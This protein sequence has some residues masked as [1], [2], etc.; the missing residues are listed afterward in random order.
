MPR[1]KREEPPSFK[2]SHDDAICQAGVVQGTVIKKIRTTGDQLSAASDLAESEPLKVDVIDDTFQGTFV[3]QN[4]DIRGDLV[5][6]VS[7]IGHEEFSIG[8]NNKVDN[9][10]NISRERSLSMSSAPEQINRSLEA[11]FKVTDNELQAITQQV[12]EDEQQ[13]L[14]LDHVDQSEMV[15]VQ[16][17]SIQDREEL[18]EEG[19]VTEDEVEEVTDSDIDEAEEAEPQENDVEQPASEEEATQNFGSKWRQFKNIERILQKAG[20]D[21]SS[22]TWMTMTRPGR[23]ICPYCQRA[24]SKPSVLEKHIRAHTGERPF[25]CLIC[26]FSFKTKSNLYKHCKSRAHVLKM[27]L[28][29]KKREL[30]SSENE[31]EIVITETDDAITAEFS[32]TRIKSTSLSEVT[33]KEPAQRHVIQEVVKYLE[34]DKDQRPSEVQTERQR[35]KLERLKSMQDKETKDTNKRDGV[36]IHRQYSMPILQ[37]GTAGISHAQS[38]DIEKQH[39]QN[40]SD[41]IVAG[42]ISNESSATQVDMASDTHTFAESDL[43][44]P[45]GYQ[46]EIVNLPD[47]DADPALANKALKD[48]EELIEKYSK[49]CTDGVQLSTSVRTL[50]DKKLQ[51]VLQLCHIRKSSSSDSGFSDIPKTPSTPL[52]G[53]KSALNSV[54]TERIQ[55]LISANA[56]IIDTPKPEPPRAKCLKRN[57]S[58]QDSEVFTYN[59]NEAEAA[60]SGLLSSN[61][62]QSVIHTS[63]ESSQKLPSVAEAS[64]IATP[65]KRHKS[66][67]VEKFIH[68]EP[69]NAMEQMVTIQTALSSASPVSVIPNIAYIQSS[70]LSFQPTSSSVHKTVIASNLKTSQPAALGNLSGKGSLGKMSRPE[71]ELPLTTTYL[72]LS[73][74]PVLVSQLNRLQQASSCVTSVICSPVQSIA[75]SPMKSP[76]PGLERIQTP[77]HIGKIAL[78]NLQMRSKSLSSLKPPTPSSSTP[79]VMTPGGDQQLYTVIQS[80]SAPGQQ[81]YVVQMP[82]RAAAT[83]TI[84][85][86]QILL[87]GSTVPVLIVQESP[88]I[89]SHPQQQ[90]LIMQNSSQG[91]QL[92]RS[93]SLSFIQTPGGSGVSLV[94]TSN[95]T[96][97]SFVHTPGT[98]GISYVLAPH[99]SSASVLGTIA[100]PGF[101]GI[102]Q[103]PLRTLTHILPSTQGHDGQSDLGQGQK[104][105]GQSITTARIL[106][107]VKGVSKPIGAHLF[108]KSPD[109]MKILNTIVSNTVNQQL[110]DGP[111][112]RAK[113]IKI[114]IQIPPPA[115]QSPSGNLPRSAIPMA[116]CEKLMNRQNAATM[117][118]YAANSPRCQTP[119]TPLRHTPTVAFRFDPPLVKSQ[120]SPDQFQP[121]LK[122]CGGS[123][124]EN[125][126][127]PNTP[128]LI[129]SSKVQLPNSFQTSESL[130]K[131]VKSVQEQQQRTEALGEK[132]E[133]GLRC[134]YCGIV[135]KK[136]ATLELHM[137]CYCKQKK[138]KEQP[139]KSLSSVVATTS[140][141][142]AQKLTDQPSPS[143]LFTISPASSSK[144]F[145]K[146]FLF[147]AL[148]SNIVLP[149]KPSETTITRGKSGNWK[150]IKAK[151]IDIPVLKPSSNEAEAGWQQKLKGQILKRK[152]KGKLL[153]K[154]S[155]S[156]DADSETR[157]QIPN[158]IGLKSRFDDVDLYKGSTQVKHARLV[159]SVDETVEGG[160]T[161]QRP[162]FVRSDSLP[163]IP[164]EKLLPL[165]A[166]NDHKLKN[167][168]KVEIIEE[169]KDVKESKNI[170][171][172]KLNNVTV[173][174]MTADLVINMPSI[175]RPI[176]Q[177]NYKMKAFV[178]MGTP[179][180][181]LPSATLTPRPELME[182]EKVRKMFSF[183][184]KTLRLVARTDVESS[185][186]VDSLKSS[187]EDA[188]RSGS[189]KSS[190][191]S[192]KSPK[193]LS[194][195]TP[196]SV[197][198]S[199]FLHQ[200]SLVSHTYP[201]MRSITH[202]TF[203]TKDRLQ[204]C[205]VKANKKISMYSNWRVA[206]Q[207]S[208]PLGLA[209]R[210][211]LSLYN[212]RYTTNPVWQ[213]N[214]GANPRQSLLTHS[215]YWKHKQGK[216]G[217]DK[218]LA[219]SL[220]QLKRK[221]SKVSVQGGYKSTEAY[222]YVRGRGRGK[223]VCETCGIRCKKPSMLKKHI[224]THTNLRPY[225]C[226][227]CKFSFKTKGN[228]TKHMKSK[229][230]SKKCLELG[231]S[232][233]PVSIDETQI[234]ESALE[235]QCSI[236]KCV[237]IVDKANTHLD[238]GELEPMLEEEECDD[239][240][241]EEEEEEEEDDEG[242]EG[243]SLDKEGSE[244]GS[245][246]PARD[247]DHLEEEK[248]EI[249]VDIMEVESI[250]EH[251]AKPVELT[252]AQSQH[253]QLLESL[254]VIARQ[255]QDTSLVSMATTQS[256]ALT[257]SLVRKSS[258]TQ[259]GIV[260][261]Q[262]DSG[263]LNQSVGS[264]AVTTPVELSISSSSDTASLMTIYGNFA[265]GTEKTS[266]DSDVIW[267]L[268]RLSDEKSSSQGTSKQSGADEQTDQEVSESPPLLSTSTGKPVVMTTSDLSRS[269]S[270]ERLVPTFLSLASG[271]KAISTHHSGPIIGQILKSIASSKQSSEEIDHLGSKDTIAFVPFQ[272]QHPFP[273]SQSVSIA[274]SE[275]LT[276]EQVVVGNQ[277]DDV[278][279][280]EPDVEMITS[281]KKL[282][283]DE[284]E[285]CINDYSGRRSTR[286]RLSGQG[287]E[288]VSGTS[289]DNS[290]H[291]SASSDNS[292]VSSQ[293]D[294]STVW[295]L[296][297]SF[298]V[299]TVVE[300]ACEEENDVSPH[301]GNSRTIQAE[302]VSIDPVI[303]HQ[304]QKK[305]TGIEN[306][307]WDPHHV[308][309][310]DQVS[311]CENDVSYQVDQYPHKCSFCSAEFSE[312]NQLIVHGNVHI[313]EAKHNQHKENESVKFSFEHQ[314][315]RSPKPTSPSIKHAI[316]NPDSETIEVLDGPRPYRCIY[317]DV[318]FRSYGYLH[319]HRMSKYHFHTLEASG[320]L[321]KG[322]W[323]NIKNHINDIDTT[324]LE[325]LNSS[326]QWVLGSKDLENQ[327]KVIVEPI[328]HHSYHGENNH[329]YQEETVVVSE[330]NA[331]IE[332]GIEICIK[333]LPSTTAPEDTCEMFICSLCHIKFKDE[334]KF[335]THMLSHAELRPF[336]CQYC[337]AGFTN[338][339]ALTLH[340]RSH[341]QELP[342]VCGPCGEMFSD[343]QLLVEHYKSRHNL[344][345][346]TLNT[347][348]AL[349]PSNSITP[350]VATT[351]LVSTLPSN[352]PTQDKKHIKSESFFKVAEKGICLAIPSQTSLAL[353]NVKLETSVVVLE[354]GN[355]SEAEIDRD[356]KS[357]GPDVC[358]AETTSVNS[359]SV[360]THLEE[361]MASGCDNKLNKRELAL[362]E[363]ETCVSMETE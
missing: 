254:G 87:P 358:L 243:Q 269:S 361:T 236:S 140:Q 230:H 225:K 5:Y 290:F 160:V 325:T 95:S 100:S 51:V 305:L 192:A 108:S 318:S 129:K 62:G 112:G 33:Q 253:S 1:Q 257:G 279:G 294:E 135:F 29:V 161:I 307:H 260:S 297:H 299:L 34:K 207:D 228:L 198:K 2:R 193:L 70:S 276:S 316:E 264:V 121:Q 132:P 231:I 59:R 168:T 214:C 308:L 234:D 57:L 46:I 322:T 216:L 204:P 306:I 20:I 323:E 349:L 313:I 246:G 233:V 226:R 241:S 302:I 122:P 35:A 223:Y 84:P 68:S 271:I 344:R 202:L 211:L 250:S 300:S 154:R 115:L 118:T 359:E 96:G 258:L 38:S 180:Q 289:V 184:S 301:I 67:I 309:N 170:E 144:V 7:V 175:V 148:T 23:H 303:F 244:Q 31:H 107:P 102:S 215:S 167:D 278:E 259:T 42:S 40:A 125:V 53:G 285:N 8:S 90:A 293:I 131:W 22:K 194:P 304:E 183:D 256:A 47:P 356:V 334:I 182:I 11:L 328:S 3:V 101:S 219:I 265:D 119:G 329:A 165:S 245:E 277:P 338:A 45:K 162:V 247:G 197:R 298:P 343:A 58:R 178:G 65:V 19:Q 179:L 360:T 239:A 137:L 346:V 145:E 188:S 266:K 221:G 348:I 143:G 274:T 238:K 275:P 52:S 341:T 97:V 142:V 326:I 208:N 63:I 117:G 357:V 104:F 55:Q 352:V 76:R 78:K 261:P 296:P 174:V 17:D 141:Y 27:N 39:F 106:T 262:I 251:K 69:G 171:D 176:Y 186:F 12:P 315:V 172:W 317:C 153:M 71:F 232:P 18:I 331:D 252:P 146:P 319:K 291:K 99:S 94:H 21:T 85:V 16:E 157:H 10:E 136:S 111:G 203:C 235:A 218:K 79:V 217:S 321:E 295:I 26:G 312:L 255:Q 311:T 130:A 128:I 9:S 342:F 213:T 82:V 77:G 109:P 32:G 191:S 114:E 159:R 209:T 185:S 206:K 138:D 324:N 310:T 263:L 189:V 86:A 156:V 340:L 355:A 49:L 201:S 124:D 105:T 37:L 347:N 113:E 339:N 149:S 270:P 181:F 177:Q 273:G 133:S 15:Y 48:L 351:R 333:P 205:Y 314:N 73:R 150:S 93:S 147:S 30:Q 249:S 127:Y 166:E 74:S 126:S 110:I 158:K 36:R 242:E 91:S 287:H 332:E 282:S 151:T 336:V 134:Q 81:Q 200:F 163:L 267:G 335:K 196:I 50:T 6:P 61:S 164:K 199:P 229:S 152:L 227:Q 64:L 268:L 24:C 92:S 44:S 80:S 190:P 280:D 66:V 288:F 363:T 14:D 222:V 139:T 83:P 240:G 173:P 41:Y 272:F 43:E 98:P 284:S 337:D 220:E 155:A 327:Q 283:S 345:D 60:I 56:A 187:D 281:E 116:I 292:G 350:K 353:S 103:A 25:P 89:T 54:L 286:G 28:E 224:R 88:T 195:D 72:P 212:S 13:I 330:E 75:P 4:T 123:M 248:P 362:S 237:K 120:G 169:E 210:P 320:K 354:T